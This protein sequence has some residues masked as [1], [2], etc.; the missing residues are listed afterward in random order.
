MAPAAEQTDD[1]LTLGQPQNP[2]QDK[3]E[4]Q[5]LDLAE[6][7]RR[8]G[9]VRLLMRLSSAAV[10]MMASLGPGAGRA[11]AQAP[12]AVPVRELRVEAS[13]AK[14]AL[15]ATAVDEL[16]RPAAGAVVSFQLPAQGPSGLFANG[17][18]TEIV[19]AGADGRATVG[20]IRWDG[21]A[22][23]V[24]VRV[25]VSKDSARAA[26]VVEWRGAAET[27]VANP[28]R[29]TSATNTPKEAA[30]AQVS[31]AKP[32]L[33]PIKAESNEDSLDTA[34]PVY[35]GGSGWG[36][37]ILLIAAIAGGVAAG[38]F[39]ARSRQAG[40][41]VSGTAGASVV[42]TTSTLT[43]GAPIITVGKP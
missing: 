16:G 26:T 27:N 24:A 37:R 25:S 38:G 35:R 30:P 9:V 17:L 40:A 28:G 31:A 19:V 20:G 4:P 43:I 21:N 42:T 8:D 22:R 29:L 1:E 34:V 3:A 11:G 23:V 6:L 5:T 32:A 10:L 13:A 15:V 36:K 12:A 33:A 18:R 41:A 7:L 2:T 39:A 14:N